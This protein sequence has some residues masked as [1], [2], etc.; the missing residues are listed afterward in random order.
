MIIII[1]IEFLFCDRDQKIKLS[2][3][4]A[5]HHHST[6]KM[7]FFPNGDRIIGNFIM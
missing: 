2:F 4:F 5:N 6:I 1:N 7:T 3:Y